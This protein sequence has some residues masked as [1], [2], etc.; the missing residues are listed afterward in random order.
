MDNLIAEGKAKPFLI[1]MTYGMTNEV[2]MGGM[3]NFDI[4][5]FEKVLVEELVPHIDANFRTLTDQPIARWLACRW[6][7]WRLRRSRCAILTS[8]RI[9]AL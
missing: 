3:Q 1:V 2:R 5:D 4:R 9:S 7:A 8:S 6:A